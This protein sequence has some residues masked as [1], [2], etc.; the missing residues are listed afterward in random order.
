MEPLPGCPPLPTSLSE[1]ERK[2]EKRR[3][4][5]EG[6][7]EIRGLFWELTEVPHHQ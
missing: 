3:D 7:A 4:W 6:I 5:R 2:E 1:E